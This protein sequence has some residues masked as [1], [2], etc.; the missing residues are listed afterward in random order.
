MQTED[1]TPPRKKSFLRSSVTLLVAER[2]LLFFFGAGVALLFSVSALSS[3]LCTDLPNP[4]PTPLPTIIHHRPPLAPSIPRRPLPVA[5]TAPR[6][7]LSTV[8]HRRDSRKDHDRRRSTRATFYDDPSLSYTIDRPITNWDSK[9]REWLRLNPSLATPD[10]VV[11]VTGSPPGRCPNPGGDHLL[12]RFYKNKAD[13]CR[14]HGYDLFYNT[15]LLHPEMPGCWA[16]IPL[17]RAAMVAH[18][19]SEWVWWVDQ[20]A[21]FTDMEFRPP[22]HR[23]RAHHFVVPGWPYMVYTARDWVGLNAGVFLLRNS[24]WGLDFLDAWASM[25]PQTPHHG[26]WG[27]I[28]DAEIRGKLTSF[29]DDQSALVHLLAK[30]QRR[31]RDKVHLESAYDLHGYWEP[32]VGRLEDVAA[33]YAEMERRDAVLRRRH[34]EKEAGSYGETRSRYLDAAA[35]GGGEKGSGK[36]WPRKRRS[37]VTHFT[38]CQPCGGDHNP[39]YTWQGCVDG[40]ARALNF[41]DDQVLRAYGFGHTNL[42]DSASIRPLP[43]GY[44]ASSRGGR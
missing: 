15:A 4:I 34:A 18:P 17:V 24:Q 19:E 23:Y 16:K 13:Y 31:W 8:S 37:F 39:A 27:R 43:F 30:E 14:L 41:A 35:G 32:I 29:A 33:A 7:P 20:D 44:P 9:R 38:G 2:L 5:T 10:R 40:M 22:L 42:N 11:M 36:R 1:E 6:P 25:G 3:S 26:K 12:L 21:A 28:L